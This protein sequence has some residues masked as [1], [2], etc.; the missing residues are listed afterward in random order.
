MKLLGVLKLS[1]MVWAFTKLQLLTKRA[2]DI[3]EEIDNLGI[4]ASKSDLMRINRLTQEK[5]RIDKL[6]N[7]AD[8]VF[9]KNH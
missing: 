8:S 1:L 5:H 9:S 7:L 2:N 3:E 6:L 4:D